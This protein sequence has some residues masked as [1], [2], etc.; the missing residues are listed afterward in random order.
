M[1]RRLQHDHDEPERA[2][3]N[4]RGDA[5]EHP[6]AAPG[7]RR[8]A[9]GCQ[10][11]GCSTESRFDRCAVD[12]LSLRRARILGSLI[13]D[14]HGATLDLADS[15]WRDSLVTGG[16]LGAVQLPGATMTAVRF[17][18]TK[19]DY[20][21][22]SG[23]QLDDVVFEG[24]ELGD[25][26]ARGAT[27]HSV[28][29]TDCSITELNVTASESVAFCHALVHLTGSR[30]DGSQSDVW[31]RDTLGL[32]KAGGVWKIAHGHESVPMQM[33]GSFRAANFKP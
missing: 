18:G 4:C 1:G 6:A 25:V 2:G 26:D 13:A 33:D 21:N 16:R 14:A 27:L 7:G 12:G 10:E 5:S 17:R 24:C 28:G 22:L 30:I 20:L 3:E 8:P 15:T 19:L 31:F 29:F 11:R 32:R 23:A 9:E